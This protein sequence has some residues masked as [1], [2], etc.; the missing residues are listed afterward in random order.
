[1]A[2]PTPRLPTDSTKRMPPEGT[3]NSAARRR[4]PSTMRVYASGRLD[5]RFVASMESH[6]LDH[7]PVALDL[8]HLHA[9]A[10]DDVASL[11]DDVDELLAELHLA[12]RPQGGRRDADG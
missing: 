8:D 4:K 2:T 12:G 7:D 9:R 10:G 11:G 1:M 6:F 5:A 3:N